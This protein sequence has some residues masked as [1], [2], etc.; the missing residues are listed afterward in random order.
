MPCCIRDP[1]KI[2][3]RICTKKIQR[4]SKCFNKK[5]DNFC[6]IFLYSKPVSLPDCNPE[7]AV[8]NSLPG[9]KK[10]IEVPSRLFG[11]TFELFGENGIN[12]LVYFILL[13]IYFMAAVPVR[14]LRLPD[15]TFGPAIP[16]EKLRGSQLQ[17]HIC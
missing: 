2:Y 9:T 12:L 1:I 4:K 6:R 14:P 3:L 15:P 13:S 16:P 17:R 5:C 11:R 7:V 8:N 10:R